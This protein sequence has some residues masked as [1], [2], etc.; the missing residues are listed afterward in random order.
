MNVQIIND[1]KE[2]LKV[3]KSSQETDEAAQLANKSFLLYRSFSGTIKAGF[4]E[5][6]ALGIEAGRNSL[7]QTAMQETFL[8][9]ARLNGEI[10]RTINQIKL[11][12]DLLN[13]GSWIRAIIDTALPER[14]PLPKPD[15]RQMQKPIGPVAVFGASNFPFA[16][17][18]A[19][20]DTIAALAAGCSVVYKAHPAHPLLSEMV[21]NIINEAAKRTKMPEGIFSIVQTSSVET[22]TYLVQHPLIKAVAFTGSV[23]AGKS[24]YD[25]AAKRNEPIPVYAEMGSINPVFILPEILKQKGEEIAKALAASNLL[26]AGQFC[27]N[28]GII[29]ANENE[30]APKF[31]SA[32][33]SV[34]NNANA[35]RM[36]TDSIHHAYEQ[37]IKKLSSSNF[38]K[39]NQKGNKPEKENCAT[40]NMFT[41]SAETFIQNPDLHEE[42]FGPF[43]LHVNANN[44][45]EIMKIAEALQGQL[46][47]T[48]LGTENDI[49]NYG[50]LINYLELKAGRIIINGVPTGVEVTHAM[51]HGGP[52]PATTDSKFTSVGSSSIY[53]FTRPVCYQN[54][55]DKILPQ[56]LQNANVL[57]IVRMVNGEYTR[58]KI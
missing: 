22:A 46:T 30:D 5:A 57:S 25:A 32:F 53:R 9:E 11:F 12:A 26:S 4:L 48:I 14:T 29:I 56:E 58:N 1:N 41:T 55:D 6:I 10:T 18:T 28:P 39:L 38:V 54:F 19:G 34:I 21:A 31:L 15:L 7:L 8:Q 50:A 47:I 44:D 20:G 13:E 27:T 33:A 35:E 37:S 51:M 23:K 16:F 42:V 17:S 3:F 45:D 49:N 24:I 40:P 52:Y 2:A 36:L 43:S